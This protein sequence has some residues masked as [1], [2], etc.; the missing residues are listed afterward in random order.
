MNDDPQID[1]LAGHINLII[2][3]FLVAGRAGAPAEGKLPF[4]PLYFNMLRLLGER[5]AMRPSQIADILHVPRT[6]VSTAVRAL[7]G[8]GLVVVEADETDKRAIAL[9]LSEEGV[10]VLSS[11]IR[12]DKRNAGAMLS[13][14]SKPERDAFVSAMGKVAHAASG[15]ADS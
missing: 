8:R 15:K 6:T 1:A 2:R 14:L 10:E 7:K 5:S 11:I 9:G 12:Q 4:N 3:G 13:V